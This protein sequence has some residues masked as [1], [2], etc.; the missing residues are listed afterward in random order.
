MKANV[1]AGILLSGLAGRGSTHHAS[2]SDCAIDC[3]RGLMNQHD[4]SNMDALCNDM[5]TQRA[6]FI[7]L[8][9]SCQS[10]T[11][12]PALAYSISECSGLGATISNL[13]PVELHHFELAQRQAT[14]ISPRF[15]AR[16]FSF[17]DEVRLS[18]DC[19]AGSDG[20]LTLSLPSVGTS[21]TNQPIP[22]GE[23]PNLNSPDDG[24]GP[25]AGL[26]SSPGGAPLPA[27]P[28]S[29]SAGAQSPPPA[30]PQPPPTGPQF[31]T[32]GP[33]SPPVG[34]QY[35]PSGPQAPPAGPQYP[36]V[37]P[38]SSP[39]GP[40]FSHAGPYPPQGESGPGGAPSGS[41][42]NSPSS[43]GPGNVGPQSRTGTGGSNTVQEDCDTAN[44]GLSSSPSGGQS[45]QAPAS[46]PVGPAGGPYP[47][48]GGSQNVQPHPIPDNSGPSDAGSAPGAPNEDSGNSSQTPLVEDQRCLYLNLLHNHQLRTQTH[49]AQSIPVAH[50]QTRT[51]MRI[52]LVTQTL[53]DLVPAKTQELHSHQLAP[54]L[55]APSWEAK[56]LKAAPRQLMARKTVRNPLL[57]HCKL[58]CL[59][60]CHS[61]CLTTQAAQILMGV[62][63]VR[64][65]MYQ[66]LDQLP[67]L[68]LAL[69]LAMETEAREAILELRQLLKTLH[70]LT[71]HLLDLVLA[72]MTTKAA[73]LILAHK[74]LLPCP[75][76]LH[77]L[78]R[79]LLSLFQPPQE[80]SRVV[81]M[82]PMAPMAPTA[83]IVLQ[84]TLPSF[85]LLHLRVLLPQVTVQAKE[86][87]HLAKKRT[88]LP[89]FQLP[90]QM[91]LLL[92][93]QQHLH[94]THSCNG[95][96]SQCPDA[97]PQRDPNAIPSSPRT[98]PPA[99]HGQPP[100][101]GVGTPLDGNAAGSE[102][103]SPPDSDNADHS[104]QTFDGEC[105]ND[106]DHDP[107]QGN[108]GPP[109]GFPFV[110]WPSNPPLGQV[111]SGVPD[112]ASGADDEDCDEADIKRAVVG[113][114]QHE[115][116]GRDPLLPLASFFR[117]IPSDTRQP[118]LAQVVDFTQTN[119][120]AVNP[121]APMTDGGLAFV[122]VIAPSKVDATE[123]IVMKP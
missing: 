92:S 69:T 67:P 70:G 106:D 81:P 90:H 112:S 109:N 105:P 25:N 35:P 88:Q 31:P 118:A 1:S 47:T 52:Q 15:D 80:V 44:D 75:L 11:Y 94:R 71:L 98:P 36:S 29:P 123:A 65:P 51:V 43:Q 56:G 100:S 30:G 39:A 21:P 117:E 24:T 58:L 83:M 82:A 60:R 34:P 122:T 42:L 40:Q 9:S 3:S 37:G 50:I 115:R 12:G 87:D 76:P 57:K 59:S 78:H 99:A 74:H 119:H 113:S 72:L 49:Q 8:T 111:N 77:H 17:A 53:V 32:L 55:P 79:N 63:P 93:Q 91:C 5:A 7:C 121:E 84:M 89:S 2:A 48:A 107:L 85:R 73:S 38:Q 68:V 96:P 4:L 27:G 33:Q 6:L 102:P 108:M 95:D 64:I 104:P 16:A 18:V 23:L 13:H 61:Q 110:P 45:Q 20:V 19:T 101:P 41:P 28:Q 46:T 114:R 10:Q 62:R 66:Q 22:Y 120:A 103:L 116:R 86:M 97:D 26:G 54:V 14:S